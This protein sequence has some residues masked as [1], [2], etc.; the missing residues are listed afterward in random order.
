MW[1]TGHSDESEFIQ[2]FPNDAVPSSVLQAFLD[3]GPIAEYRIV[4][5]DVESLREVIR[6][7]GIPPDTR[8][9]TIPFPL[10]DGTA[11]SIEITAAGEYHEGWQ[12]GHAQ[13]LGKVHDDELTMFQGVLAPDGS[14][15]L[16]LRTR[17]Q[18]YSIRKS[19]M[20]PYH[21]YYRLDQRSG[22]KKID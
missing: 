18:R 4:T 8:T 20:L 17:D 7:S 6:A 13:L 2:F 12:T 21:F 19:S 10:L 3:S 11:V 16:T 1:P 14:A 5:V 15:R 22:P 9:F